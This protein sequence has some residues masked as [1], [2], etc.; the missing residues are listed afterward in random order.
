MTAARLV[1]LGVGCAFLDPFV[2]RTLNNP[3][4]GV[5]KLTPHITHSYSILTPSNTLASEEVNNFLKC[6]NEVANTLK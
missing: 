5:R 3:A 6:L 4:V 2:A 1:D